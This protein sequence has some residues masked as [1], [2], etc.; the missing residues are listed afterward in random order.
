MGRPF[1]HGLF[2]DNMML[3]REVACPVWGWTTPGAIITVKMEKHSATAV[4][5]KNGRWQAEI[6]PFSA[7]GPYT[8]TISGPETITLKNVMT[9]D[10]WLCSGQSNMEMGMKGLNKWWEEQSRTNLPDVRLAFVPR[11]SRF[12]RP[13]NLDISWDVSTTERVFANQPSWGGFSAIGFIFGRELHQKLEIPIGLIESCW[14]ATAIAS[15]STQEAMQDYID[16]PPY[17]WFQQRVESAWQKKDPAYAATVPWR[18]K[19]FDDSSWAIRNLPK[20]NNMPEAESLEWFRKEVELPESWAGRNLIVSLGPVDPVDTLWWN[21]DWADSFD[22]SGNL[23]FDRYYQVSGSLVT[24]G[25]NVLTLRI[26]GRQ[27]I[28]GTEEQIWVRPADSIEAPISLAG[29]WKY[30][31]GTP[32]SDLR[33]AGYPERR[34]IPAGCFEGMI[35]SITPFAIKGVIWYQ[36]EGDTGMADQYYEKFSHMIT[37][38]RQLFGNDAMPFYFVQL[39]GFGQPAVEPGAS[40]WAMVREAQSRVTQ[41]IPHT[42]MAVAIDRG[43]IYNIHPSNKQDVAKRLAAVALADTYRQAVPAYGPTARK[44]TREGDSLRVEFD[45]A[46][47]GLI[48]KGGAPTGFAIAGTDGRFVWAQGVINGNSIL[49]SSPRVKQ[50]VAVRYGWADNPVCNLYNKEDLPVVPFSMKL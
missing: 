45:H 22:V 40:G 37:D 28:L 48:S 17:E 12:Q 43:D 13:N 11:K 46:T 20:G 30:Q 16:Q 9:G 1:V 26:A 34:N 18:E 29:P 27:G 14:G 38:W 44:L 10:V 23:Q 32:L 2:R 15:W 5:D 19:N 35:A 8:M 25:R 36:G 33:P 7:G 21:G 4:A 31:A 3:Q 42:G 49:I 41:D 6:G 39:A 50:P 24:G 47:N